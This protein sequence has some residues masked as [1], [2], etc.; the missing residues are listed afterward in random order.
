MGVAAVED[1][2]SGVPPEMFDGDVNDEGWVAWRLLPSTL[3]DSDVTRLETEYA[4][5]FP[6]LF[7][8][9]L[10]AWFQL[11]DQIHSTRHDQL[12]FNTDVPSNDPLGPIS[13]LIDAWQPL[14][15]AQF[16]PF[17]EWGDGW[18]PMC[19]DTV[20]RLDDGDCPIVWMDHDLLIPLGLDKL[21]DREAVLPHVNPLYD[22]YRDFFDDA[23]THD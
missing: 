15:S 20:N 13:G 7:R 11:F 5:E 12:I 2:G 9:Y 18:G 14:L 17:A 10:L 23:F 1:D 19:F 6:P 4:V 16:V 3:S 8:A 22:S 21:R